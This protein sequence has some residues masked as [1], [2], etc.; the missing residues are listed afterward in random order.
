MVLT[1]TLEV[2]RQLPG[3]F[4]LTVAYIGSHGTHLLGNEGVTYAYVHTATKLQYKNAINDYAPISQ[5]YSGQ[6][7]ANLAA[8]YGVTAADELPLSVLLNPNPFYSWIGANAA[9]DGNNIYHALHVRLEKRYSHGL[10]FSLA[11]TNSKNIGSPYNASM[12]YDVVDAIH[13]G[14][15]RT[16]YVGGRNGAF[17]GPSFGDNYQDID[18]VRGDRTLMWYDIPQIINLSATYQFPFGVGRSFL[19]RKGVLNQLVGGWNL[20]PNFNAERG[21]PLQISGPCDAMTCRPNLIGNPKAVPGG[22]NADHWINSAAFEPPYGSDQTFWQNPDPNDPRYWQF[23]TAGSF[24]PGLR[25]PGFWTLDT[26]LAK[27]FHFSE[28]KYFEFRW[29]IFNTLNH[30]NLGT[31]NTGYC[32]PANPDGSTDA[33]HSAGCQFG[34]ITNIQTDPRAMQFALKFYW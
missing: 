29:E 2:Q 15:G 34:R 4:A 32:L 26:S 1:W 7:A 10:N 18:N 30:Q 12:M 23:G 27:Q 22:Q 8:V 9:F 21:V 6:Q 31:P 25:S 24:L 16:G 3:N 28:S 13:Q 5:F 19:N 11:Y 14:H 17:M 20:T 33:V